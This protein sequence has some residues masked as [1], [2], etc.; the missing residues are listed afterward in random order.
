MKSQLNI[1]IDVHTLIND[2]TDTIL[3]DIKHSDNSGYVVV[4]FLALFPKNS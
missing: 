3:K 1:S 2:E 4:D